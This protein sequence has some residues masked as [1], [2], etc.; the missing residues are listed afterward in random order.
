MGDIRKA[1]TDR[2]D[3]GAELRNMLLSAKLR[4]EEY[5]SIIDELE[6]EELRHDL[7]EY[8][9]LLEKQVMPLV[10]RA[11]SLGVKNLVEMAEEIKSIYDEIIG[12]IRER[13]EP[14]QPPSG[15]SG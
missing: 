11:R 7:I 10:S 3:I 9:T 15:Y 5:M 14:Q 2:G 6:E 1:G 12:K 13:I 8:E 4:R